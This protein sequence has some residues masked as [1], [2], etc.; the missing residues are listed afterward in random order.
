M[1]QDRAIQDDDSDY[2][3]TSVMTNRGEFLRRLREM[4]RQDE[5]ERA[6]DR[7]NNNNMDLDDCGTSSS[8]TLDYEAYLANQRYYDDY[9]HVN[10]HHIDFGL[11]GDRRVIVQQDRTVGK[12][13]FV[14]DA[15][16]ILADHLIQTNKDLWNTSF[17]GRPVTMVELGAGTGVTGLMLASAFPE[18]KVHLTDMAQ[19]MPLLNNNAKGMDNTTVGELEWGTTATL[20]KYD[21]VIGADVVAS[22]YSAP[23]LAKAL[24]DLSTSRSQVYLAC[25]DRLTGNIEQFEAQLKV[26]FSRVERRKAISSNKNPNVWIMYAS[27]RRSNQ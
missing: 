3:A 25:R 18:S 11:I 5:E 23:A 14:W 20:D 8:S 15:G 26:L 13:G 22:I 24:Y 4:E 6:L 21:V 12:G 27:G 10:F 7:V 16:Y 2:D 1:M 9:K 17:S 19:L